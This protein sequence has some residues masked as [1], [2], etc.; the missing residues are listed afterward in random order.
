MRMSPVPRGVLR[1]GGSFLAVAGVIFVALRLRNYSVDLDVSGMTLLFFW[2]CMVLSLIYGAGNYFLAVSWWNFIKYFGGSISISEAVRVYGISQLAKYVPGNI[3]H[4]AG[5]QVLGMA[6]GLTSG[7]AAKS[8]VFEFGLLV[9][10][11]LQFSWLVL[12]LFIQSLLIPESIILFVISLLMT[13]FVLNLILG[14]HASWAFFWQILFLLISSSV[15]AALLVLSDSG[16]GLTPLVLLG[17]GG[18][19]IIAWL[20]GLVTPG[21]PAGVGVR[22]LVLLLLLGGLIDEGKLLT[23]ILIG[24]IVTIVGDLAFFTAVH[25]IPSKFFQTE[26]AH[27]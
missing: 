1:I 15:F 2:W 19:F 20:V 17:C 13:G 21:A 14:I 22:E 18:G 9:L 11:G 3:F 26:K 27:V 10:A 23:A 25:F 7:I 12:P 4:L 16:G 6:S 8:M 24:R 5:R